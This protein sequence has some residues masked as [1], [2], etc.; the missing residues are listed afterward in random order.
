ME[1]SAKI[2]KV[3]IIIYKGKRNYNKLDLCQYIDIQ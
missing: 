2:V 1:L 3:C